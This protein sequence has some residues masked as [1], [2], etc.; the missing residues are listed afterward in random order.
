MGKSWKFTHVAGL[1]MV[2]S[3]VA[4]IYQFTGAATGPFLIIVNGVLLAMLA[5]AAVRAHDQR[6]L[7]FDVIVAAE[8]IVAF[9]VMSLIFSLTA[10][11]APLFTGAHQLDVNSLKSLQSAALP[12]LEGLATAGV[13]PLVAMLVRNLAVEK[14]AL[15]NPTGEVTDL[16]QALGALTLEVQQTHAAVGELGTAVATAVRATT[17]FAEAV[18]DEANGL[19]VALGVAEARVRGLGEVTSDGAAQVSSLRVELEQLT[20]SSTSARTMLD[21]LAQVIESAE[22]F[23]A[24]ATRAGTR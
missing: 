12:F 9:G 20:A 5:F 14:D 23:I 3:I 21:T 19:A 10:A 1:A 11:L 7:G 15:V 6:A 16:A 22:R 18:K 2:V 24:P 13:A 8:T 17:G 4:H